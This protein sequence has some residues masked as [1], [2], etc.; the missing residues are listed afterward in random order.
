MEE[1]GSRLCCE[2]GV[3]AVE[4]LGLE[5][6]VGMCFLAFFFLFCGEL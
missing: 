3:Y 4:S 2:E 5:V 1:D 6:F